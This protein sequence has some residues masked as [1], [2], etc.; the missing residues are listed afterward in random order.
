MASN[1][2]DVIS[3]AGHGSQLQDNC[4]EYLDT[5]VVNWHAR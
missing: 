3:R 5:A 2:F 4:M 1:S